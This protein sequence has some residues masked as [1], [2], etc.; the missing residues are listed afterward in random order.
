MAT[1]NISLGFFK[2]IN[3]ASSEQ[4]SAMIEE[5]EKYKN[6]Q[7]L[8]AKE[9]AEKKY[10]EFILS[11]TAK[12]AS[13][14]SVEAEKLSL[15]LKKNVLSKRQSITDSVFE[16]VVSRINEFTKS[17]DYKAMLL[18]S[19]EKMVEICKDDHITV[20]IHS[21]DM[22]FAND[23]KSVSS[24]IELSTDDKITLGGM[25]GI[26]KSRSVKLNDLLETRLS[27]QKNEFYKNSGLSLNY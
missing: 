19:A 18:K 6:Q 21:R 15:E 3:E 10:E 17:D 9:I 14:D 4:K 13:E 24:T 8:A 11:A 27:V 5:T 25:Y 22:I 2:A 1:D 7:L 20:Y 12:M 23:I 16:D 26:C